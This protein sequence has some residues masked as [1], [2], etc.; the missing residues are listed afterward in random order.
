M[1]QNEIPPA[2]PTKAHD[3]ALAIA[4]PLTRDDFLRDLNAE[5]PSRKDFVL[6]LSRER[7]YASLS[8][9]FLWNEVYK[10][11]ASVLHSCIEEIERLG[12]RVFRNV[13]LDDLA[14]LFSQFRVITLIT[15]WKG[16]EIDAHDIVAP[17]RLIN[18]A[19]RSR[20]RICQLITTEYEKLGVQERN[21]M[22]G[23]APLK[24]G[25][26]KAI[27]QVMENH[28][29]FEMRASSPGAVVHHYDEYY[30][31][32]LNRQRIDTL[33]EGMILPGNHI[34]FFDRLRSIEDVS[35]AIPDNFE[36]TLD[37]TVCN[38][39]L[40]GNCLKKSRQFR[41]IVNERPARLGGRMLIYK[42]IIKLL[43]QEPLDYVDALIK[44]RKALYNR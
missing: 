16:T 31:A 5:D 1:T 37:F 22:A 36:G 40:I 12:V 41:V 24:V 10:P 19:R 6:R 3:C 23:Q 39:V 14:A 26:E 35:A 17:D 4:V 15:H 38:S 25:V 33:F 13:T 8:H 27:K 43:S 29:L 9:E 42:S 44:I 11:I 2:P 34:E 21:G 30:R 18:N 20:D 7:I 28:D 32:Y